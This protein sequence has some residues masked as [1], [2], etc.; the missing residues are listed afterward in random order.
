[1]YLFENL[2]HVK[3]YGRCIKYLLGEDYVL[4]STFQVS[5]ILVWSGFAVFRTTFGRNIGT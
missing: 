5:G 2:I 4:T 1:M 3:K